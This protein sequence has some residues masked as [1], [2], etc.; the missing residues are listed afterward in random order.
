MYLEYSRVRIYPAVVIMTSLV[1]SLFSPVYASEEPFEQT[2]I[3]TAYYSPLPNQCCYFRGN[4]EEEIQFNGRG[5]SGAD[6]TP[7]Y[8]GMIAA[9]SSYPF[10]TVIDLHG[11]GVG[12]V[13][14]RGGRIVEWNADQHRIDLWM[15]YG[16][17]GLARA[18]AWGVQSVKGTVFPL[19]THKPKESLSF[20]HF[21]VDPTLL[22]SLPKSDPLRILEN[23][24]SGDTSYGV[25]QL[26]KALKEQGYFSGSA[27]GKFGPVTED[28]LGRFKADYGLSG[29]GTST[30]EKTA[31][32]LTAASSLTDSNLPLLTIG[33]SEGMKGARV[34]QAQKLLRFLGYYRGRTD[35]IYDADV[36]EAVT[37]LQIDHGVIGSVTDTGA[38][39]IGP[40]T[41][42]EIL[43][44]WKVRIASAKAKKIQAKSVVA[45]HVTSEFLPKKVLAIGDRGADVRLLQHFLVQTGYLPTT[46]ATGTFAD[47]T[48]AALLQYQLDRNIIPSESAK[49]AGVF[50][51]STKLSV[52]RDL[53][54][55]SWQQVRARGLGVL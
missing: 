44:Q 46:D 40:A 26:Q 55:V 52:S 23:I 42:G 54:D 11:L 50:G 12:T 3:V 21:D 9:P 33:L 24:S 38:G 16:E 29:D 15:G 10:G 35:G 2:F 28:A 53:L 48:K 7:V 18:L 32:M 45:D 37:R 31:A 13:H 5:I 8:L 49:G 43:K 25:T 20:A 19:G 1:G 27:T 22:A 4:Y 6:G 34:R 47:R 39:R 51:P 14:D 41:Q 30:N 17:E 36:R